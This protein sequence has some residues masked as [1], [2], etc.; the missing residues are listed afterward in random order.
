[1]TAPLRADRRELPPL[2]V[3]EGDRHAALLECLTASLLHAVAN[4]T[5]LM[6]GRAALLE[7]TRPQ[8]REI[9]AAAR[10]IRAQADGIAAMAAQVREFLAGGAPNGNVACC[11]LEVELV[12][13]ALT[14]V[15][16]ARGV[17]IDLRA[18]PDLT[19]AIPR[20]SLHA[21]V[22]GLVG[23]AAHTAPSSSVVRLEVSQVTPTRDGL[24]GVF[25]LTLP[26]PCPLAGQ[27]RDL[28]APWFTGPAEQRDAAVLLALAMGSVRARGGRIEVE[29][30][31][32]Q[33]RVVVYLPLQRSAGGSPRGES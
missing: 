21:I 26:G 14:P 7:L 9:A 33:S 1:M 29:N 6:V 8:D 12:L 3:R 25:A 28:E 24:S 22:Y 20:S 2:T 10:E 5:N 23:F 13:R 32:R 16:A 4:C 31:R 18:A 15:A 19:V 17:E 30:D 11:T 27:R